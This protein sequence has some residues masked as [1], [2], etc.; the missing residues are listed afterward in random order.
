Y[1]VETLELVRELADEHGVAVGIVLHDLNQAA[2]LADRLALVH[3]GKLVAVGTPETVLTSEI[4][5]EVYGIPVAVAPDPVTG[6]LTIRRAAPPA[7]P[8]LAPRGNLGAVGT[9][10]TVL[11]PEILTE[12][13]GIPVAGAPDPVT[14]SPPTRPLGRRNQNNSGESEGPRS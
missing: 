6:S 13:Y 10:E 9:P 12:V 5:T 14:G 3:Q 4:L 2:A 11:T 1:Q 8:A 7:R